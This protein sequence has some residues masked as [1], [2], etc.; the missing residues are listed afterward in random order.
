MIEEFVSRGFALRDA[1]HL[2]HWA[3]RSYAEHVALGAFYDGLIDGIDGI[4][5]AY[6][7]CFGLIKAVEP[8]DYKRDEILSQIVT[9]ANWIA[10]NR[11]K[12]AKGNEVLENKLDELGGL[13]AST[14][15]KLRF[16]K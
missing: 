14:V 9:E 8:T 6:Q 5:E 15:Y 10:E 13:Y 3:T 11:D 4:I 2:A 1:A 12:I 16:L 7:G